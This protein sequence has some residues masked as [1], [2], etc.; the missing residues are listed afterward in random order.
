MPN[1]NSGYFQSFICNQR[2]YIAA[3]GAVGAAPVLLYRSTNACPVNSTGE[4]GL[5]G[6]L[7]LYGLNFGT[8]LSKI[9]V[10]IG[11]VEVA[12]YRS[13]GKAAGDGSGGIGQ[14]VYETFGIQCIRVQVGALSGL[15]VGTTYPISITVNGIGLANPSSSGVFFNPDVA[16]ALTF[17]PIN[18][19]VIFVD[20]VN[21]TNPTVGVVPTGA[22]AATGDG[23]FSHPVQ[24]LQTY[25]TGA[26]AF[27]GALT[28]PNSQTTTPTTTTT[29]PPGTQIVLRG[30]TYTNY[31]TNTSFGQYRWACPWQVTGS[32]P[33]ASA[34]TGPIGVTSYPG[35][36]NANAPELAA[37]IGPTSNASTANAGGFH[38]TDSARS[39]LANTFNAAGYGQWFHISDIAVTTNPSTTAADAAPINL[40][41]N[42]NNWWVSNCIPVWKSNGAQLAQSGGIQVVGDSCL[43]YGNYIHDIYGDSGQENHGI[44]NGEGG[45][46]AVTNV[47]EAY[48]CIRDITNP[49][50]V[51]VANGGNGIQFHQGAQ[52][53]LYTGCQVHTNLILRTIKYGIDCVGGSKTIDCWNNVIVDVQQ[54]PLYC[55]SADVTLIRFMNNTVVGCNAGNAF[56][57]GGTGYT[58]VYNNASG[59]AANCI[60]AQNNVLYQ[61]SSAGTYGGYAA[62]NSSAAI[63]MDTNCY[64]DASGGH[65][66]KQSGDTGGF[67]GDPLFANL[68]ALDLHPGIS[69]PLANAG[70]TPPSLNFGAFDFA[71]NPRPQGSNTKYAVGA[72]ERLG[73]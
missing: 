6:Y 5:G 61:R 30:G 1:L 10:L 26:S 38:G 19:R 57:Y 27:G 58:F 59:L 24:D 15:S 67:Y 70:V 31:L 14:G 29:L 8:D 21:G 43:I 45:G 11:G 16:I 64:F 50:G 18:G 34:N 3:A 13:V 56:G 73:G 41:N 35:A 39:T 66:S 46:I 55:A 33:G 49:T 60:L 63:K 12:N 2:R 72:F 65:T 25:T 36:I 48:N 23:G 9:K 17:V 53:H 52:G 54:I 51:S 37:F 44:Y 22:N 32:S 7:S 40:Q 62:D 68:A 4:N 47:V 42:A 20:P 69:S 28:C 71:F